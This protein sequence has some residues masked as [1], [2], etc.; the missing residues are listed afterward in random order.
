MLLKFATDRGLENNFRI[1][2]QKGHF[3][4]DFGKLFFCVIFHPILTLNIFDLETAPGQAANIIFN[5]C[6]LLGFCW[7]HLR[8]SA[9]KV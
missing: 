9:L 8:Q 7:F 5:D 2:K 3:Y 4:T 6:I 1:V